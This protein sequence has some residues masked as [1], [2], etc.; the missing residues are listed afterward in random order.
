MIYWQNGHLIESEVPVS[1]LKQPGNPGCFTTVRICNGI[2]T[3][4]DPHVQRILRDAHQLGFAEPDSDLCRRA[5]CELGTAAF[6]NSDGIVRLKICRNQQGNLS[7]TATARPLGSEPAYWR[8]IRVDFPHPGPGPYPGAKLCIRPTIERAINAARE[9][10]VEESILLDPQGRL[11]EGART[12]LLVVL[13]DGCFATPPLHSGCVAGVA[14]ARIR[15][16]FPELREREIESQALQSAREIIAI[17]AVRGARAIV[18]LDGHSIG[19]GAPGAMAG[20][21]AEILLP[22]QKASTPD[23]AK[24]P[25]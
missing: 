10:N 2:P 13:E 4:L 25:Q 22:A 15:E 14:R 1:R 3:F 16:A 24:E 9:S 19:N 18:E 21:V 12:N 8:A 6:P 20:R 23:R 5:L 17:N 11:V 7:L